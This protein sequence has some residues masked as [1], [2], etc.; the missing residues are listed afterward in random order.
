MLVS[1]IHDSVDLVLGI[2][3]AFELEG[4]FY[5]KECCF[6]FLNRSLPIFPKE[7]V[8]IK[9]GKQKVV[10]V[11]APFTDEISSLA[12]IK[13]IDKLM[14]NI[15]V[16]KVKFVH[17]IAMLDVINNSYSKTL[18]LNAKEAL[19]ILEL[20]SLGYYKIKQEVIQQKLSRF[21]EFETA[22]K[23]YAQFNNLINTLR[24]EQ[25]TKTEEKCPWL[26]DSDERNYMMDREILEK[27]IDLNNTC[28]TKKEKE[29][30]M[31]MLYKYREAF[32]LRDE[33]STCPNIEVG[34][35]VTDKSPLFIRP[36]YIREEDKKAI[37]KEMKCLCYLGILKEGFLPYSSPVMLIS[38]KLTQD[39]RVITDFRYLNVRIAK[40]NIAYPLV[41]DTF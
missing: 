8:I 24:Q 18:I 11:E 10:K 29:E 9:P 17:N 23:I 37:D 1:E 28:L 20:R 14:H 6:S 21:Y 32:S 39:K 4:I 27:Y 40:I 30:V 31:D 12:I 13:L 2:K 22:D 35:E 16:L 38:H 34:I 41:R 15:M 7:E 19:G 3:S 26:E 33:I 5:A 36:Y 25:K